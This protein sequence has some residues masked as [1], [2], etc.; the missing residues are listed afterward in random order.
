MNVDAKEMSA[1]IQGAQHAQSDVNMEAAYLH[2]LTDLIQ[3]AGVFLS[4][5]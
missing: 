2:V 4:G 1:T 5:T 3:S